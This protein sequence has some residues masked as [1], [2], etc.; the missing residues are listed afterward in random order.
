MFSF[1]VVKDKND[2]IIL[3][4]ICILILM[5]HD[6]Q[7]RLLAKKYIDEGHEE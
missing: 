4:L 1:F 6:L 5:F 7:T 3:L 2:E